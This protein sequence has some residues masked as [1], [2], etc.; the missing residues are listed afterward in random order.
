MAGRGPA[1]KDPRRRAR[2]NADPVATTTI[3]FEQGRQPDLPNDIEWPERTQEW[4]AMWGR[5][6]LAEHFMESDWDFLLDTALLHAF[7]WGMSDLTKLPELRVRV[8]K[9]GATPEDRARL[10]IQFADA[11]EADK[12]G[13]R[14]ESAR[15]RRGALV[16]FP[17]GAGVTD[18]SETASDVG[19][20]ATT[21]PT[22]LVTPIT[23][24]TPTAA[25]ALAAV[26]EADGP[27]LCRNGHERNE[28]NTRRTK[29]G[30]PVCRVC[31][32]EAAARRREERD[33]G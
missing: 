5:S 25:P 27:L 28:A 10:R 12:G 16:M 4:W 32:R 9:F 29:R 21:A 14:A 19:P 22:T 3:R 1:P 15:A 20:A 18:T 2:T 6:P 33:K 30:S 23:T 17:G 31:D 8:A 7:V 24:A 11:D 13:S 26:P